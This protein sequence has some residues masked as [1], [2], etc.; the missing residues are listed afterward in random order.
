[1]RTQ[2]RTLLIPA[3]VS[4]ITTL[5]VPAARAQDE[6]AGR[7]LFDDAMTLLNRGQ[8][9]D[10]C[11]KFEESLRQSYNLNA[12]YFLADCWEKL[13]RTASAWTT[14][15]TVTS[16]SREAGDDK[17]ERAARKRADGLEKRL[18]RF[19]VNVSSEVDGLEVRRNGQ[20]VGRAM[21]GTAVPVDPGTYEFSASA[22]GY[23]TFETSLNASSPGR[24]F[25]INIPELSRK[26]VPVASSPSVRSTPPEPVVSR[27]VAREAEARET[28]TNEILVKRPSE[29]PAKSDDMSGWRSA[30][31]IAGGVGVATMVTGGILALLAKRSYNNAKSSLESC[32]TDEC[33]WSEIDNEKNAI[34]RANLGGGLFI[35]GAVLTA[36]AGALLIWSYS[37]TPSDS[38]PQT[39][40]SLR[41]SPMGLSL[42]GKL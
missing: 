8:I 19:K 32:Q 37:S 26:S 27:R 35:G 29:T 5:A 41:V 9:S 38:A 31:W 11:P 39:S 40:V 15:L 18:V 2:L 36:A 16:R 4:L 20:L 1:M 21:W 24:V 34:S 13:G 30:S 3:A 17:R 22:P 10:A 14:F 6:A 33:D 12:Q 23:L 7:V 42:E 28:P 25:E